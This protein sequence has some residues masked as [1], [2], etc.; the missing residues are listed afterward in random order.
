MLISEDI[1]RFRNTTNFGGKEVTEFNRA[2][3]KPVFVKLGI[4]VPALFVLVGV[5]M[6][7]LN[8]GIE[9]ACIF[10]VFGGVSAV[11]MPFLYKNVVKRSAK[12][13]VLCSQTTYL[14]YKFSDGGFY[15][16]TLKGEIEIANQTVD[17]RWIDRVV[18]N[19]H[20]LYIFITSTMCYI[21]DKNGMTFG[22]SD[23][24]VKFLSAKN[25][26]F[27]YDKKIAGRQELIKKSNK[28]IVKK[29]EKGNKNAPKTASVDEGESNF[30]HTKNSEEGD[31]T[32]YKKIAKTE[33]SEADS[34]NK[35]EDEC[36][37]LQGNFDK[38]SF[39]DTKTEIGEGVD[40]EI[41]ATQ[42]TNLAKIERAVLKTAQPTEL[43]AEEQKRK[44]AL[45][46]LIN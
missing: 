4:L 46:K 36:E 9:Y 25:I 41:D 19:G 44:N 33:Q 11:I 18:E 14:D 40:N 8:A 24:I 1:E 28:A 38:E 22:K 34:C 23:D 5:Y 43:T 32:Q 29:V 45:D 35:N 16:K 17:Y 30:A 7:G 3:L 39:T 37:N 10:F 31:D 6:L 15:L 13:N 27:K 2:M 12:K 21:L 20:Y 26:K 42:N